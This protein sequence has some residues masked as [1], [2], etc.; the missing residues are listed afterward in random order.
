[1]GSL[2]DYSRK[3]LSAMSGVCPTT[4]QSGTSLHKGGLSKRGPAGLRRILFLDA[5]QTIARSKAMNEFHG[6]M[7]AKPDSSKMS[8]KVACMRKLLLVLRGIVVSKKPFDPNHVS[9]KPDF[10]KEGEN[11]E[12]MEKTA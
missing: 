4:Q 9:K 6:R 11:P 2:A 3:Q 5:G 1:M 10:K 7:L 8:A 12:K